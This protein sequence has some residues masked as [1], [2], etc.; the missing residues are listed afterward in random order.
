ML[1]IH[2]NTIFNYSSQKSKTIFLILIL[3]LKP[4][5]NLI[6][7]IS[8]FNSNCIKKFNDQNYCTVN[9]KCFLWNANTMLQIKNQIKT[10]ELLKNYA[11]EEHFKFKKINLYIF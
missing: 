4:V 10:N 6:L 11:F 1:N 7:E 5:L 2:T 9:W 8:L 3:T